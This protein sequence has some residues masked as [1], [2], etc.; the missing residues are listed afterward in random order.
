MISPVKISNID[1]LYHFVAFAGFAFAFRI[2]YKC[3]NSLSIG[4][5]SVLLGVLIEIAQSVIPNRGFSIADMVA[6]AI[7]VLVGLSIAHWILNQKAGLN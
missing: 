4:I 2:A 5:V 1:K 7:G 6:D 3:F